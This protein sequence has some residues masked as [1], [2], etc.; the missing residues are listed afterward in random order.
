MV[1]AISCRNL[2]KRYK[3]GTTALDG[4]T[5]EVEQGH[6]H[7]LV[8][9]NGAGKT[10]LMKCLVNLVKPT[11]GDITVLGQDVRVAGSSRAVGALIE[12]PAF[13][14]HL[15]ARRNL[16]LFANYFGVP[17]SEV[18]RVLQIVG[19]TQRAKGK[20]TKYS[21]GMKQRLGV[22]IAMLGNPPLLILDE[23]VNGLDPQAIADM[24]DALRL[25]RDQGITVLL[26]SHLLGEVDQLCDRVSILEA[27]KLIAEG[28]P[29]ELRNRFNQNAP[30]QVN[31]DD[32]SRATDIVRPLVQ[33]V[34]RAGEHALIMYLGSQKSAPDVIKALVEGGIE[35]G[36]FERQDSLEAAYLAITREEA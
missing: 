30:V 24:R 19:L 32:V 13:Y 26:S 21:L 10:T 34:E 2:L 5:L 20:A 1:V 23:P 25:L 9:R 7:G 3:T 18:D 12:S 17:K 28:T 35:V 33:S 16:E 29:S 27:G 15:S 11:S 22:A 8:G 36:G 14:P 31:V 6:I 4:V